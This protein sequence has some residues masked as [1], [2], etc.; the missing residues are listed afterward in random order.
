ML[1]LLLKN[2]YEME[3]REAESLPG[4]CGDEV[5]IKL[6][7]GGICG[8]DLSVYKGG[9]PYATYPVRPGHEL[10]G[11]IVEAGNE[12]LYKPGTRVIVQP[13][14]FCGTCVKCRLGKTNICQNKKSLGINT[15]G[16][17]SEE[18]IISS[19][20][21]L[22]VPDELPDEKAILIEPFAVVVHALKKVEIT[23]ASSVAV[24]GCGNEGKL[25]VLLAS[26]LGADVTAIDIHPVK[27][28]LVKEMG[29]NIRAVRPE[30]IVGE[31]FDVVIEAAG[32]K[33]SIENGMKL[34]TPG[35]SMVLIGITQESS[36]P[37]AHIVRNEI[38][39]YGSI[40]YQFPGDFL[41]SIEYLK[42]DSF[43]VEPIISKIVP[44]SDFEHAFESAFSGDYGKIILNFKED[45]SI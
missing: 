4:P 32:T 1:E 26:Y 27:L 11:T 17:F 30:D 34:V 23:K 19:K 37:V 45:P 36:F 35:G 40:I 43:R 3:L 31:T 22:P 29:P 12:A 16:G 39:L 8:T 20:F 18:F 25:A 6:I 24:I 15:D 7:Y 28:D 10:L 44:V 13:N 41:E 5:K 2:P 9:I 33:T 14:T 42:N 38:T 21:V